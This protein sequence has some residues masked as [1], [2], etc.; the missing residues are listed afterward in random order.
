MKVGAFRQPSDAGEYGEDRF[1]RHGI[2]GSRVNFARPEHTVFSIS[3]SG[4]PSRRG[5]R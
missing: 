1:A 2:Y 3:T 4:A 5:V